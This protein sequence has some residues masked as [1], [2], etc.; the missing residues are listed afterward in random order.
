MRFAENFDLSSG[1]N[2]PAG[3]DTQKSRLACAVFSDKC[4]NSAGFRSNIDAI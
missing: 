1:G 4:M 2:D 3:N